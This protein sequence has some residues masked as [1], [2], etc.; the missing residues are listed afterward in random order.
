ML[1][2]GLGV[3]RGGF[4]AAAFDADYQAVLDR[5][6]TLGYSLPTG[7]ALT[8]GEQLVKDLKDA[9]IW[10]KLDLFYVF[11]TNG[12]SDFATLNWKTPAS[13][14]ATKVNSPT[15]T[16]LEG[17]TGDGATSYLN[18]NY[19]PR[20]SGV[21]YQQDS[22]SYGYYCRTNN[23]GLYAGMGGRTASLTNRSFDIV[24][25]SVPN[26]SQFDINNS[27]GTTQGTIS[28][29]SGF[30]HANRSGSGTSALYRNGNLAIT[31][32]RTSDGTPNL[33]LFV[34]ASNDAGSPS[35]FSNR[36]LSI[37]FAGA[38]LLSERVDFFNAIETYMDAIGKGVV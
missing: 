5:G 19:N 15:F 1:G 36:Q 13:F 12:D 38:S 28:D 16:S 20:T 33:P 4:V 2:L 14:Q 29:S 22:A 10:N 35:L 25:V 27:S 26:S 24:G 30:F 17:F 11:A 18:T 3:N 34:L 37:A 6:T 8:A 21:N 31:G 7:T 23:I 32:V 9:G